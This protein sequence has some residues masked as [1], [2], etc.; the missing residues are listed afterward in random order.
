MRIPLL[1]FNDIVKTLNESCIKLFGP[2][3]TSALLNGS[4]SSRQNSLN[5]R[6]ISAESACPNPLLI[7][8][9]FEIE[10]FT[11]PGSHS[12]LNSLKT[13]SL[14]IKEKSLIL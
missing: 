1:S 6:E 11:S 3:I 13:S 5:L 8:K 10:L 7:T 4:K 9:P 2:C 14:K 12:C